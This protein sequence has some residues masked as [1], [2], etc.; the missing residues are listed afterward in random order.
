MLAVTD[1]L[2]YIPQATVD[3]FCKGSNPSGKKFINK[4]NRAVKQRNKEAAEAAEAKAK[5]EAEQKAAAAAAGSSTSEA[6]AL[7]VSTNL[8]FP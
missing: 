5:Q 6:L 4:W 8:A 1:D 3:F 2:C 7:E